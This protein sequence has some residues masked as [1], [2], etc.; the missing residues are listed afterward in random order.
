MTVVSEGYARKGVVLDARVWVSTSEAVSNAV[1][2]ITLPEG[3]DYV[4]G[5][6]TNGKY[7]NATRTLVWDKLGF[8]TGKREKSQAF[9]VQVVANSLPALLTLTTTIAAPS[10]SQPATSTS[11]V[12]VGAEYQSAVIKKDKGGRAK[13][14]S[15]ITLEV[16]PNALNADQQITV[17][18]F[19]GQPFDE[20][21]QGGWRAEFGP[22]QVFNTPLTLT[23]DLSDVVPLEMR[24]GNLQPALY[25]YI[26]I[27]EPIT[28]T[29]TQTST[30]TIQYRREPVAASFDRQ[31]GMMVAT[32]PHFSVLTLEKVFAVGQPE[33]WKLSSNLGGVSLFRGASNYSYP[34]A[35][36]PMQDGVQPNLALAYSSAGADSGAEDDYH[37]G[38]GWS[39]D[40]PNIH[41]G[42]VAGIRYHGPSDKSF[43][44]NQDGDYKLSLGGATYNLITKTANAQENDPIVEYV[45]E[46]NSAIRVVRCMTS[47][48][49][50]CEGLLIPKYLETSEVGPQFP[51][52]YGCGT[53]SRSYTPVQPY[54]Q[55][56]MP[57]GIRYLFGL[58]AASTRF[59]TGRR[60]SGDAPAPPLESVY[61]K[62]MLARVYAPW[63]DDADQS[64]WSASYNY[65]EVRKGADGERVGEAPCRASGYDAD[66]KT[67]L[68]TITYGNSRSSK[69]NIYQV[70]FSYI[71]VN[72]KQLNGI[73]VSVDNQ[74]VRSYQLTTA[75]Y[76][77]WNAHILSIT[78]K[79][80]G[81]EGLPATTFEYAPVQT[82]MTADNARW[83]TKVNN[84]YGGSVAYGYWKNDTGDV[85]QHYLVN[86]QTIGDGIGVTSTKTFE[87]SGACYNNVGQPCHGGHDTLFADSRGGIVGYASA[88]EKQWSGANNSTLLQQVDHDFSIDNKSIGQETKTKLAGYIGPG[89]AGGWAML[90]AS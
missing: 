66:D 21:Q 2:T 50:R 7:D 23:L 67:Y 49:V 82:G 8:G 83:L 65:T 14:S 68:S 77:S 38:P 59:V 60:Q 54:W 62:W 41:R 43:E 58:D 3:L 88:T 63:R 48:T 89:T 20:Q 69:P 30:T 51:E 45:P 31:T 85:R 24:S 13:L 70:G 34:I 27:T 39:F 86:S 53:S 71:D 37:L 72:G 25:Y 80:T 76:W 17:T 19:A 26:P 28:E 22:E 57:N 18:E 1:I 78:E 6:G 5:S 40:V 42:V 55:V 32:L 64:K 12:Q 79:G 56:W 11:V 4:R 74:I 87:Y 35:V 29:T 10:V 16:P 44:K 81:A 84:G 73:T 90:R 15:R 46:N 36:P 9:S 75:T 61:Q 47:N 52:I 33:P